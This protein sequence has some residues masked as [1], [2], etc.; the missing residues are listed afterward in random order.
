LGLTKKQIVDLISVVAVMTIFAITIE[1]RDVS[2]PVFQDRP[3]DLAEILERC[4]DYCNRLSGAILDFVCLERV[5]ET[6]GELGIVNP[7]KDPSLAGFEDTQDLAGIA[8]SSDSGHVKMVVRVKHKI[9]SRFVY[10]YQLIKDVAGQTAEARTLIKENGRT[11]LEKNASLKT[12]A[13]SYTFI[14]MGPNTLLS[15]DRQSL[16]DYKIIKETTLGKDLAIIIEAAPKPGSAPGILS[17]KIWV[18]KNDAGVLRIEWVPES[19]GNYEK[20]ADLAKQIEAKPRLTFVTEFAFEQNGI[21]FPSR[22]TIEEKYLFESGPPLV[23][24]LT[25]VTQSDY[26]FFTVETG[27]TIHK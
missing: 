25:K 2:A 13:F 10:D 19:I 1:P 27:V 6:V 11:V 16:F 5:D 26:R 7:A 12:R 18:R 8:K 20:I 22:Y 17:G 21:R 3:V 24:S 15:R 4:A 9:R 14:V 23:R